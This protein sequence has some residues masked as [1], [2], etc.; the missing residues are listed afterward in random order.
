MKGYTIDQLSVGQSAEQTKTISETDV[1]LFAG[2]TGDFNPAHVNGTYAA[3]TAFGERIAHGMLSAGLISA[4]FG[5][6]MPGPGSVYV[7]QSLK[8]KAP[9]HI[10]DT[11]TA[12]ATVR[13]ILKDKNRVIFDTTCENQ[14]GTVV[15][16]G[17]AC[18]MPPKA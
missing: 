16:T 6:Q 14:D 15:V 7:S 12:R 18:L 11:I 13:E 4:V 9:V 5:T 1:Y 17:E 2:V 8:F 10:G 3:G